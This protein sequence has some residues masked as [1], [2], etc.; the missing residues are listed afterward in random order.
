MESAKY[1]YTFLKKN[2]IIKINYFRKKMAKHEV[3]IKND[4]KTMLPNFK[5]FQKS[6]VF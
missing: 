1:F 4:K 6:C 2:S 3:I 5:K